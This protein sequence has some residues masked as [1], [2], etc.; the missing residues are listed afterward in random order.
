MCVA[1][2]GVGHRYGSSSEAVVGKQRL[3]ETAEG[4]LTL[5][6]DPGAWE[7]QARGVPQSLS[8]RARAF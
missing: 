5:M 8:P 7:H 6:T 1:S 4:F 2:A 3:G